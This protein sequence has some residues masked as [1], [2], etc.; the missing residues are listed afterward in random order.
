M[1][2]SFKLNLNSRDVFVVVKMVVANNGKIKSI[3]VGV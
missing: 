2:E 1:R 3:A